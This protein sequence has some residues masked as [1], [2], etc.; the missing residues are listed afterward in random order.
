MINKSQCST[1]MSAIATGNRA[2][3]LA[4]DQATPNIEVMIKG[5]PAIMRGDRGAIRSIRRR[6]LGACA[7]SRRIVYQ[8]AGVGRHR[9]GHFL[10]FGPLA[11]PPR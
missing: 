5:E 9:E 8:S 3:R 2:A 10:A 7:E 1:S 6:H 11:H 4:Q